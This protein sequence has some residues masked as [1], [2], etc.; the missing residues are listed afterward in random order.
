MN[1]QSIIFRREN[2]GYNESNSIERV[3]GSRNW[4]TLEENRANFEAKEKLDKELSETDTK[5][6]ETYLRWLEYQ[7]EIET[8]IIKNYDK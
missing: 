6:E 1:E 4:L 5:N 8:D 7:K 3:P 2:T